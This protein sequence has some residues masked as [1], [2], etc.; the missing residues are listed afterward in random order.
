[1]TAEV[2]KP[3]GTGIERIFKATKCSY[4]GFKAAWQ[5]ESAFRQELVLVMMLLPLSFL[6]CE[7]RNHW[8]LLFT[9]LML[10]IFAELVNSAIEAV[11]DAISLEHHV[12]IGRAKDIGSAVVFVALTVL[13]VVW[14]EALWR[15][16]A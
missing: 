6:L 4:Y 13:V 3:N 8:L 16:W 7:S 15:F 1:M 12:L 11:A 2:N 10:V 5:Y 9:S 14:L